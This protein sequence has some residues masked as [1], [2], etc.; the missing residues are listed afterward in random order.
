VGSSQRVTVPNSTPQDIAS[1]ALAAAQRVDEAKQLYNKAQAVWVYA[2]RSGDDELQNKAAEIRL[3]AE[4]RAGELLAE[5]ATHPSSRAQG[6]PRRDGA[7]IV[8]KPQG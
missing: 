7:K 5:M 4:L 2:Q 1:R 6:R 3:F 8:P